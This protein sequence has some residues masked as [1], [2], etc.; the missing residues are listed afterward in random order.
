MSNLFRF[1][2]RAFKRIALRFVCSPFRHTRN[3]V[4]PTRLLNLFLFFFC[5]VLRHITSSHWDVE[6]S[7]KL[8]NKKC[9][10]T[11]FRTIYIPVKKGKIS[12]IKHISPLPHT[13]VEEC[14][15]TTYLISSGPPYWTGQ[16]FLQRRHS[17]SW[18][19]NPFSFPHIP[20]QKCNSSN[21]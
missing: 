13:I 12:W 19:S 21:K 18:S 5:L 6:D 1:G 15:P 3:S 16:C 4:K 9:P 20:T 10:S 14:G 7:A 11:S 17:N 2:A 8:N